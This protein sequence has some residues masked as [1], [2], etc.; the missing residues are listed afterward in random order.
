MRTT[1]APSGCATSRSSSC[2]T[3]PASGWASCAGS[4]STTSTGRVGWCASSA[5]GARNAPCPTACPPTGRSGRGWSRAVPRCSPR[6]RARRCSSVRAA[7]RIDQRA[8]RTLVHCPDRRR[9]GRPRHRAARPAAHRRH[10]PARGRGRPAHRPGA[11]RARL[12]V[13]H[14]DLHPRQHRPAAAGLQ[15][16]PPAGLMR[17]RVLALRTGAIVRPAA[18]TTSPNA[19]P[20]PRRAG[21]AGPA[22]HRRGSAGR[23]RRRPRT[24]PQCRQA[25][26]K[27]WLDGALQGAEQRAARRPRHRRAHVALTGS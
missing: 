3:R 23:G 15:A 24:S 21:A 16:G 25:R 4:T 17:G 20:A 22:R 13:D 8:V 26:G 6:E 2:S 5:R 11:A 9:P 27:Q 19:S 10:P 14:A 12:A 1:A 7:R 18:G